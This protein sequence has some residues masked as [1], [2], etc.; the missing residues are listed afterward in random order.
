M[1]H[2]KK[3][4]HSAKHPQKGSSKTS[5]ERDQMFDYYKFFT[6]VLQLQDGHSFPE[7]DYW[8]RTFLFLQNKHTSSDQAR[9]QSNQEKHVRVFLSRRYLWIDDNDLCPGATIVDKQK[10]RELLRAIVNKTA[11]IVESM[12]RMSCVTRRR[13]PGHCPSNEA[14][15]KKFPEKFQPQ[16]LS[17]EKTHKMD[18]AYSQVLCSE[19]IL[20][21]EGFLVTCLSIPTLRPF[22]LPLAES[23]VVH[24][25][26]KMLDNLLGLDSLESTIPDINAAQTSAE[27]I[28]ERLTAM[29]AIEICTMVLAAFVTDITAYA[30]SNLHDV[31]EVT[32]HLSTIE[33]RT[34]EFAETFREM[35]GTGPKRR[36]LDTAVNSYFL[37][38]K[39]G[40]VLYYLLY[41]D[42]HEEDA[43]VPWG[44]L[45]DDMEFQKFLKNPVTFCDCSETSAELICQK[46]LS[47]LQAVLESFLDRFAVIN[48]MLNDTRNI[49]EEML[50][51][52]QRSTRTDCSEHDV[53]VSFQYYMEGIRI[54][55]NRRLTDFLLSHLLRMARL[56][57]NFTRNIESPDTGEH[58]MEMLAMSIYRFH[59][60][61]KVTSNVFRENARRRAASILL[62][63]TLLKAVEDDL[64]LLKT[65]ERCIQHES[66][67]VG[68]RLAREEKNAEAEDTEDMPES[69][70]VDAIVAQLMDEILS[71][72]EL[73]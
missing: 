12:T 35:V 11:S 73:S 67:V 63:N 47:Q 38:F 37:K 2:S 15:L 48:Q 36:V 8:T 13:F 57:S 65:L 7:R 24:V 64:L 54:S 33:T 25:V 10:C 45:Q 59:T 28:S 44:N 32:Q 27:T 3:Q 68:Q 60:T 52:L 26:S 1:P 42:R 58:C 20:Y 29:E 70:S 9:R 5:R 19:A 16:L 22:L 71:A 43:S 31:C 69:L 39:A 4:K 61:D 53:C 50:R 56:T 30:D 41:N 40:P 23:K 18:T 66:V 21:L 51:Y 14:R 34:K 62:R 72:I 6:D 49:F 17:F 55:T 46:C